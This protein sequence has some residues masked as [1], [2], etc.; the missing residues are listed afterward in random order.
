M[1]K[2]CSHLTYLLDGIYICLSVCLSVYL[3]VNVTIKNTHTSTPQT[4]LY[5]HFGKRSYFFG[6]YVH[7]ILPTK[8]NLL[9]PSL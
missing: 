4:Y 9:N 5:C 1:Q 8:A 3:F 6:L 2:Q 7:F